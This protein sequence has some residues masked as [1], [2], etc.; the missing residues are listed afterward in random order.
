MSI[1]ERLT[2]IQEIGPEI[3]ALTSESSQLRGQLLD[4]IE[5]EFGTVN[6]PKRPD[7]PPCEF[8][9]KN[10]IVTVKRAPSTNEITVLFREPLILCDP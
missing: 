6:V 8:L 9:W 4:D 3:A 7:D 1:T 2:R 5:N 10:T